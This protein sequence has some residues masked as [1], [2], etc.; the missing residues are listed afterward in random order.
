MDIYLVYLRK[1]HA[2]DYFSG[3]G[4]ENERVLTMKI[5]SAFL[6]VEA[7]YEE[8]ENVQTVFKKI[9]EKAE[10]R[11]EKTTKDYMGLLR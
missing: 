6:R 11:I 5:S 8:M 7:D 3:I 2:F 4:F 9:Q 10:E 1:V